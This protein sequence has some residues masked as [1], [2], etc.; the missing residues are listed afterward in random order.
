[1]LFLFTLDSCLWVS[2]LFRKIKFGNRSSSQYLVSITN[3]YLTVWNLLSC[4]G[5]LKVIFSASEQWAFLAQ[6]A[7]SGRQNSRQTGGQI[8]K[9]TDRQTDMFRQSW[10]CKFATVT[11]Y[12]GDVSSVSPFVRA[13]D[14]DTDRQV[15]RR[16]DRQTD[17]QT[18]RQLQT[19]RQADGQTDRQAGKQTDRWRRADKQTDL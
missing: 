5:Q 3:Q 14:T 18:D 4:S 12:K 11:S 9:Q 16:I 19:D 17:R 10:K 8:G 15:G 1:M 2:L 6:P 13:N 7:Q